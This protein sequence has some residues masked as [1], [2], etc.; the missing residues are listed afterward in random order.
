[1]SYFGLLGTSECNLSPVKSFSDIK[2][3]SKMRRGQA[4]AKNPP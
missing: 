2:A 3:C 4:P 1:M